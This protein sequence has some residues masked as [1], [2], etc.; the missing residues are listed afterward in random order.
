MKNTESIVNF[1]FEVA[2]LR[3]IVRSHRQFIGEA[4]DNISDHSHRVAI[5]GFTLAKLEKANQD[6]VLKMCLFHDL[7][8]A[9]VGDANFLNRQYV[10]Q[11]ETE[12][13]L[14]QLKN[15]P[16]AKELEA[17]FYEYEKRIS[18]ESKVAKDADLLDQVLVQQEYFFH[19]KKNKKIW[20]NHIIERL[21]TKS[22]REIASK[23]EETNP[24]EWHY[25]ASEKKTGKKIKR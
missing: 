25:Q 1:F 14:D 22:A 8:E 6:K 5:I 13:R 16:I 20:Q 9:R 23:I 4:N 3:R 21:T 15:L 11:Q 18:K 7:V 19:D 17:I 10:D 24:F 2:S 12:A